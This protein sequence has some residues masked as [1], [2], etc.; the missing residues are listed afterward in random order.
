MVTAIE[1]GVR[2][3]Q[4]HEMWKTSERKTPSE[5]VGYMMMVSSVHELRRLRVFGVE[6]EK[7][8]G[9]KEPRF[10]GTSKSRL[11]PRNKIPR[12]H[13]PILGVLDAIHDRPRLY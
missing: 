9:T 2:E 11:L 6:A 5:V 3:R 13:I 1:A 12:T 4:E 7:T 8:W 10:A